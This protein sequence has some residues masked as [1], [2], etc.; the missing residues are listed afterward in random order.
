[1]FSP[2]YVYFCL[3]NSHVTFSLNAAVEFLTQVIRKEICRRKAGADL[4]DP[5]TVSPTL[6]SNFTLFFRQALL[7]ISSSTDN[8]QSTA[9]LLKQTPMTMSLT[10]E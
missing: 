8:K 6:L 10:A 3:F 5:G 7:N 4:Q 1:M 9:A 2:G